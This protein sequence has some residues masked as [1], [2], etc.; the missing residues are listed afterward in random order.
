MEMKNSKITYLAK[1][2]I[3]LVVGYLVTIL[4]ILVLALLLLGFQLTEDTVNIGII[5]IYVISTFAGG[6]AAGKQLKVRKFFWGMITGVIYY[7]VLILVSLGTG[8]SLTNQGQELITV[9]LMCFGG[10][11]L[12]GMIS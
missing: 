5:I 12:G 2:T 11:T 1:I 8:Q 9:F 10:G 6:L 7:L 3:S 4:G